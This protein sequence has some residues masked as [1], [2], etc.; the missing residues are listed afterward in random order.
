MLTGLA[1]RFEEAEQLARDS[2]R[3]A[4]GAGA[5]DAQMH[6]TAQ[7][8][9]IRRE[10]GRLDELLPKIERLAQGDAHAAAW[11]SILP[12]AYL[13]AGDRT[14]ARAAYD[15]AMGR[16]VELRL[17]TM[18]WLTATGALCEAAAEL[19]DADGCAIAVRRTR[20]VRGPAGP[21][22]LHRQRRLRPAR[23]SGGPPQSPAGATEAREHFEAALAR[24]AELRAP[25][26]LART[27]CD[28]GELLLQGT[29]ADRRRGRQ[30]LRAAAAAARRLD[31]SGV[32]AR[33]AAQS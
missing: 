24:H 11:R 16:A 33:A 20:P 14:R 3:L 25:A 7:L 8:V 22:E 6:F 27:R 9:A 17:R 23:C 32:G 18:L 28:Y 10:Q 12:L 4:E 5:A 31:L 21:V 29:Q 26:L 30:L 19:G 1:G 2:V 15:D 13:D